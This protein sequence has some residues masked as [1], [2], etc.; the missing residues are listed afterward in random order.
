MRN[1]LFLCFVLSVFSATAGMAQSLE[2]HPLFDRMDTDKSGSLS[3]GEVQKRF[4]KFTDDMF[5]Q[6]DANHDG[7][8]SVAEWQTFA[9]AKRAERKTAAQTN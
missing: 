7:T 6:A 1:V 4:P 3:K 9:K 5:K 8:L 2:N